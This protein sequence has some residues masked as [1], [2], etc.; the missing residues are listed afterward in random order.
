MMTRADS[1]PFRKFG[2]TETPAAQ[3]GL[4]SRPSE[5]PPRLGFL[6]V[7]WIGRHRLEA[8]AESGLADVA[9]LA[10]C[11]FAAAA[12]TAALFRGALPVASLDHLLDMR[13]DGV[14]IATPTALHADQAIAALE[15]GSAVFCQKPLGRTAAETRRVID[16]ARRK[17][18]LLGVDMSYRFVRGIEKIRE[19]ARAQTIG[20]IYAMDLVFHNAYGP[21]KAWYYDPGL[22]GGGCVIDLGIHLVDLALSM[23]DSPVERVT[24][25]LFAE[26]KPLLNSREALED[27]AVARLDFAGGCTANLACSWRLAAGQDAVISATFVGSKGALTCVNVNG[28]FYDFRA[29]HLVGTSRTTLIEPPDPWGGR[30]AV[31]WVKR[32][33]TGVEYDG[34]IENAERVAEVLDRIYQQS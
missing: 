32:L 11:D 23:C 19:L 26:G 15:S 34:D 4:I 21:D 33:R 28:S 17:N 7:G 12:R 25:R 24:S 31:A 1:S 3:A 13:P 9:A 5:R 29:E 10:D 6:G 20:G 2:E 14:V 8:I 22:S 18:R 16:A 27:Y 30:A